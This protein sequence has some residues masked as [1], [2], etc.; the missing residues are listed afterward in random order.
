MMVNE[1]CRPYGTLKGI[2][3]S[4]GYQNIVPTGL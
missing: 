2:G 4:R 1:W 3:S